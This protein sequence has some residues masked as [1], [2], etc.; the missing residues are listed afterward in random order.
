MPTIHVTRDL[1][2]PANR[3]WALLADFANIH[4]WNPNLAG[5]THQGGP[6]CGVGATRRCD[7][8]DGK[9]SIVERVVE[10]QEG[11]SYTVEVVEG[12][13]PVVDA[14]VTLAVEPTPDGG[15]RGTI[16]MSYRP[17]PGLHWQLAEPIALR[18]MMRHMLGKVLFG[19]AERASSSTTAASSS[20]A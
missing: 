1:A 3:A 4:L 11:R 20:A 7:L 10:W 8:A 17:K 14:R 15:S 13:M 5:S 2:V 16:T 12:T 9:N 6:V 19:L 18:P